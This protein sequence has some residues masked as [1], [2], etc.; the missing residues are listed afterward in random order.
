MKF[1]VTL[2]V[3]CVAVA[4]ADLKA[5]LASLLQD[6]TPEVT[7]ALQEGNHLAGQLLHHGLEGWNMLLRPTVFENRREASHL[8]DEMRQKLQTLLAEK[9]DGFGSLMRVAL[10]RLGSI[11][12]KVGSLNFL[13]QSDETL[14]QEI[15]NVITGHHTLSDAL[16]VGITNEIKDM[17][18]GPTTSGDLDLGSSF[19]TDMKPHLHSIKTFVATMGATLKQ[20]IDEVLVTI[21]H[22]SSSSDGVSQDVI[23]QLISVIQTGRQNIV[24]IGQK[25]TNSLANSVIEAI[26]KNART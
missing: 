12:L 14:S 11:A 17:I 6:L 18:T 3:T 16:L 2:L 9:A 8:T 10:G 13:Q 4:R 19:A 23:P 20:T 24:D 26:V 1:I 7:H 21:E 25:L 22:A 15:E 5:D